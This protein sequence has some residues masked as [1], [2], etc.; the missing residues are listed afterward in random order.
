[1][2]TILVKITL[3][4]HS[5]QTNPHPL[6]ESIFS[7]ESSSSFDHIN[8]SWFEGFLEDWDALDWSGFAAHENVQGCV[9]PLRPGVDRDVAL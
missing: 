6:Y 5:D 8:V 2:K 3:L 1:M 9:A 4:G 7:L